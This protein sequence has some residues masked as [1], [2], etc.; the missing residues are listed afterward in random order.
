MREL[1][2]RLNLRFLESV[3]VVLLELHRLDQNWHT[4]V[5]TPHLRN[6]VIGNIFFASIKVF[7]DFLSFLY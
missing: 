2:N 1:L 7:G 5:L 3:I 4:C 6:L